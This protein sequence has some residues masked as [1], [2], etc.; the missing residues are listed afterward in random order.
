MYIQLYNGYSLN[1]MHA[2]SV[3][4]DFSDESSM[5]GHASVT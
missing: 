3:S 1:V 2:I 4:V 5:V